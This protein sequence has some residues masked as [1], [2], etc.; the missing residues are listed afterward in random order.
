[1]TKA[2]PQGIKVQER[3]LINVLQTKVNQL[4]HE[5]LLKD[6]LIIQMN[7]EIMRLTVEDKEETK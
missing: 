2:Q 4:Q 1:M 3:H 5:N 7:E 6:A